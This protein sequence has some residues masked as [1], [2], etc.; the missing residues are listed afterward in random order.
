MSHLLIL[1][2]LPDC[3]VAHFVREGSKEFYSNRVGPMTDA[4]IAAAFHKIRALGIL[5]QHA[6]EICALLRPSDD[7]VEV[8]EM[9]LVLKP[10]MKGDDPDPDPDQGPVR[11]TA[12][13]HTHEPELT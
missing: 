2:T 9:L 1:D 4:A 8:T 13:R 7:P 11:S 6:V 5:V 10:Y 3:I 12:D